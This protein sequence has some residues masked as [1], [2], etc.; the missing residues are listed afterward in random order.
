MSK[1]VRGL[2]HS[3]YLALALVFGA[4]LGSGDQDLLRRLVQVDLLFSVHW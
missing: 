1:M 2:L 3:T 4:E